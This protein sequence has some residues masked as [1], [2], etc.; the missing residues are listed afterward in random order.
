MNAAGTRR[1]TLVLMPDALAIC[2]LPAGDAIP[3]WAL[4]GSFWSV[5]RTPDEMSIVTREAHVPHDVTASRGWRAIR[6]AGPLPLDQTGILA[7]VTAPLASAHIS[8]FAI[9]TYDTDFVLIP[10]AQQ[11][12]AIATLER[13]GHTVTAL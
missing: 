7:S 2:R 13:A 10:H 4:H 1:L 12:N 8:L 3:A 6:F 5:T 11:R 9:G